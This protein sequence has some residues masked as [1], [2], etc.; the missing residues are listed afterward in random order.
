[1]C[2]YKWKG[3]WGLVIFQ[4]QYVVDRVDAKLMLPIRVLEN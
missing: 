3:V 1:M 4:V 2:L